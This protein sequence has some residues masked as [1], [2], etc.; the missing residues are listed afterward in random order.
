MNGVGLVVL[1]FA[2]GI[3][4][5]VAAYRRVPL[6]KP[7]LVVVGAALHLAGAWQ[8][9]ARSERR[10]VPRRLQ[11]MGAVLAVLG[12]VGMI[13]SIAIEIPFRRAWIDRGHLGELVTTGTYSVSRHPGVLWTLLWVPCAGLAT[14]SREVI[15]YWPVIVAVDV[16]HVWIQD[17]LLLPRVFGEE[18]RAY[19]RRVPFLF[20]RLLRRNRQQHS[21]GSP[22]L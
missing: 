16:V 4:H 8:L 13:Y 11:K 3:A 10:A 6:V 9:L 21:D 19:Q 7:V 1:G 20:P 12:F 14:C 5:D 2:A 18:Y 17:R 15:R 22:T